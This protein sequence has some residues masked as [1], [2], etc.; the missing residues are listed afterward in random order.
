MNTQNRN[1]YS[2]TVLSSL[3]DIHNLRFAVDNAE[4]QNNIARDLQL[5]RVSLSRSWTPR[6]VV[7]RRGNDLAGVVFAKE[8]KLLRNLG[9][10]VTHA[11]LTF[12]SALMGDA[13]EQRDIFQ[14][15]LET[16]LA[17][18]G[19]RAV[20]LT[21]RQ[22]SPE[23]AAIQKFQSSR[24]LD[25]DTCDFDGHAVLSLP[26]TYEDLLQTFGK[27]TRR[28][29]RYYQ[30]HFE[31]AGHTY[32]NELSMSELRSAALY[33]RPNCGKTLPLDSVERT[34]RMVSS[35]E[36][37]MAVG[38]KHQNGEWLSVMIGVYTPAAG[39]LMMQLNND[40]N[41]PRESLS[42]VLRSYLLESLINEGKTEMIA[43]GG[44]APPLDRYV[45]HIRTLGIQL[46]SPGYTW[47]FMRELKSLLPEQT[48]NWIAGRA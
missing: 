27:T 2:S 7:V 31:S 6:V 26:R 14:V 36:R 29:F 23:L 35:A 34:L 28:N 24:L 33:L 5:F 44:T 42:V 48:H 18:R 16:L 3:S 8:R 39:V 47:R 19:T 46:D 40:R 4:L 41:F 25:C 37:P 11:D 17:R 10:G 20:R 43:W 1:G 21:V 9:L 22:C 32:V 13:N 12:G 15:A 45:T 38:L 30:R